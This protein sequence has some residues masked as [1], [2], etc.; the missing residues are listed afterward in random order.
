[1]INGKCITYLDNITCDLKVFAEIPRKGDYIEC[2]KLGLNGGSIKLKVHSIT[3]SSKQV[4]LIENGISNTEIY[5]Y[6]IVELNS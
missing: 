1:M 3:H 6:I 4:T 5:P 2:K